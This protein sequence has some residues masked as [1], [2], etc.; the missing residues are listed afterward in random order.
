MRG[1]E[2]TLAKE[3]RKICEPLGVSLDSWRVKGSG[4]YHWT[5]AYQGRTEYFVSSASPHSEKRCIQKTRSKCRRAC[6]HLL[7]S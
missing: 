2:R 5:L 4:H 7:R 6:E 1:I 3:I